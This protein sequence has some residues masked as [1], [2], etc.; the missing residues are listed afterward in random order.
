[1]EKRG[2]FL[3][4]FQKPGVIPIMPGQGSY[5]PGTTMRAGRGLAR[6]GNWGCTSHTGRP[7]LSVRHGESQR[8]MA[9]PESAQDAIAAPRHRYCHEC[10]LIP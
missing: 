4:S 2:H 6:R 1:M 3:Y 7:S 8:P 10:P 5:P 9:A